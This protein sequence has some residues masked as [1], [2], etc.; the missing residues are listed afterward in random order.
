MICKVRANTERSL[1]E[2]LR[3]TEVKV[4]ALEQQLEL[5]EA[6]KVELKSAVEEYQ[7]VIAAL[8]VVETLTEEQA[9]ACD[10]LIHNL[11]LKICRTDVGRIQ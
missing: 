5:E 2:R 1:F 6:Q 7:G 9:K 4:K 11:S 8:T 10:D 3:E